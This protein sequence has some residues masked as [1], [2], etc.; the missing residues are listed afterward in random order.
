MSIGKGNV[1]HRTVR[2]D[3]GYS[4][5][6]SLRQR[7]YFNR[8]GRSW[9]GGNYTLGDNRGVHCGGQLSIDG[10]AYNQSGTGLARDKAY[11]GYYPNLSVGPPYITRGGTAM[12]LTYNGATWQDTGVEARTNFYLNHSGYVRVKGSVERLNA[13]SPQPTGLLAWQVALVSSSAGYTS[14]G[15]MNLEMNYGPNG[16]KPSGEYILTRT[17][18][19][20]GGNIYLSTSRPYC[21]LV[22]YGICFAGWYVGGY[23]TP[24]YLFSDW[25]VEMT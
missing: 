16:T 14:P 4:Q 9:A 6:G 15:T 5:S 1:G 17:S 8:L 25:K 10:G 12:P 21:T 20:S 2:A 19:Y 13:S 11:K 24:Y 22:F 3:V 23:V 7:P 18:G